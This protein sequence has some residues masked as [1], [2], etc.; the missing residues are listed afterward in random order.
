M[1]A[2]EREQGARQLSAALQ[3]NTNIRTLSLV[4]LDAIYVLPIVQSLVSNTSV[5]ELELRQCARSLSLA[6]SDAV[7]LLLETTSTI[8]GFG[9]SVCSC[10]EDIFRPI[11]QGLINSEIAIDVK[12]VDC[13]LD[14][15]GST[16]L[17][18]SILQSKPNLRSLSINN[19]HVHGGGQ[20][21]ATIFTNLLRPELSLRSFELSY[22]NLNNFGL[23]TLEEFEALLGAVEKSQ[24]ED[25][26]IG[27]IASE[28]KC[29]A[30]IASIPRIQIKALKLYLN[31]DI[32][33]LK[34]DLMRAV[35][36]NASLRNVVGEW[37]GALGGGDLFNDNDKRR[38]NYYAVRNEDIAQ[39]IASPA[40]LPRGAWPKAL[41][42]AQEIGL[43]TVFC[44]LQ[45]LS[46]FIVGPQSFY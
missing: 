45:A 17:F 27:P 21:S 12:F 8:E 31:D 43:D 19:C 22:I 2:S 37:E 11:A 46:P 42:A 9:L 40:T 38:L 7:R 41:K 39:W 14:D 23:T 28:E 25:F 3:R 4:W 33:H 30:L 18:K 36:R 15:E 29:Q 5:K 26:C 16:L 34:S 20:L 44:I 32:A 13:D 6:T 35:K 10:N 1:E 24:L